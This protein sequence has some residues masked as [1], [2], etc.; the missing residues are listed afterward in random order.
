MTK[1]SFITILIHL[2]VITHFSYAQKADITTAIVLY[3][4]GDYVKAIDKL[5]GAIKSNSGL[6]DNDRAKA[7]L[8]K[9]KSLVAVFYQASQTKDVK[10]IEEYQNA[11]FDAYTCYEKS[12]SYEMKSTLKRELDQAVPQ[13]Y[14]GILQH[15]L[16]FMD[17][18]NFQKATSPR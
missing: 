8:Y 9:G 15:G 14:N 4:S 12:A 11:Y 1:I 5:N 16:V 17:T 18:K 2:F 6:D 13:L 7:W 10:L 3:N